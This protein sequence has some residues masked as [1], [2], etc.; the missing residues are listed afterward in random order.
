MTSEEKQEIINAVL[1]ALRTNSK[2]IDQLTPVSEMSDTDFLEL[3]GGRKVSYGVLFANHMSNDEAQEGWEY[4]DTKKVDKD[5]RGLVEVH[6]APVVFLDAMG[7]LDGHSLNGGDGLEYRPDYKQI[8]DFPDGLFGAPKA[9]AVYI[10]KNNFKKFV[11]NGTDL[12]ELKADECPL[13]VDYS[14]PVAFA[15]LPVGGSYYVPSSHKIAVKIDASNTKTYDPLPD[16]LYFF[17]DKGKVYTWNSSTNKWVPVSS[18]INVVNNLTEGGEADAL[19]AEQGKV[20]KGLIDNIGTGSIAAFSQ[21]AVVESVSALPATG[22]ATT[23]YIVGTHIYA[24]VG[25]GGDT[26]DGK[27]QDLGDI[28]G[29]VPSIDP[30][31]GKWVIGGVVT[32]YPSRGEKG[33]AAPVPYIGENGNW[34]VGT[35]DTNVPAQGPKGNSVA[36]GD[37]FEIVNNLH[38]GGEENALS[39]EQGKKLGDEVF[40]NA[41]TEIDVAAAELMAYYIDASTGKWQVSNSYKGKVINIS[42][43][44][45]WGFKIGNFFNTTN[46]WFYRFAFLTSDNHAANVAAAFSATSPYNALVSV[47]S[48]DDSDQWKEGVVPNDA[49]YLY[50]YVYNSSSTVTDFPPDVL[51]IDPSPTSRIERLEGVTEGVSSIKEDWFAVPGGNYDYALPTTDCWKEQTVGET[52]STSYGSGASTIICFPKSASQSAAAASAN[53]CYKV[54]ELPNKQL[55]LKFAELV[56][57][58]WAFAAAVYDGSMNFIKRY[59]PYIQ[60]TSS[61]DWTA[62]IDFSD[63][64]GATYFKIMIGKKDGNGNYITAA[65]ITL[66]SGFCSMVK[67]SIAQESMPNRVA[68]L[69]DRV[70]ELGGNAVSKF[71]FCSYNIGHFS[72]GKDYD[73]FISDQKEDLDYTNYGNSTPYSNYAAQLARWRQMLNE[74]SPDIIAM[75]EYIT[76]FAHNQAGDVATADAIFGRYPYNRVGSLPSATSYMRTAVFANMVLGASSEGS[77][78]HTAQA[79]RYYQIVNVNMGGTP[80]KVVVTH[81]D[82]SNDS[83]R[84]EQMQ[85]L[86]AAFANDTHV[87]IC[88]DFNNVDSSEFDLFT[89]AGYT[90]ANHEYLGDIYTY[91]SSGTEVWNSS[92]HNLFEHPDRALDNIMVKGFAM[93]NVRIIDRCDLTDH[94]GVI[95]DLTL[96]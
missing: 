80:V 15:T 96:L 4:L 38:D 46:K 40:D 60:V 7:I 18:D 73:T 74:Y 94:C 1:A 8:F 29:F 86:I 61:T 55:T 30:A 66:E 37:T 19:S 17:R 14:E 76:T 3:N 26:A 67:A 92:G 75:C 21:Y 33:D 78:P 53:D 62:T 88:G 95:C 57:G 41:V 70:E 82:F 83:Y 63:A 77:Y 69:E 65:N 42:Q 59:A 72:L 48:A 51:F 45:G 5:L 52:G 35:N 16:A 11:W 89:A 43:Y 47:N 28:K 32:S 23:G 56:T 71:S 25:T 31:T 9:G 91:P 90:M 68:A 93:S 49:N 87:I 2:S 13:F 12:E 36:D 27:Y 24:Y 22:V 79:G 85:T 10:S 64:A 54:S 6:Q 50:V 20:L 34:W 58:N 81:L 44:R 84:I 39:A